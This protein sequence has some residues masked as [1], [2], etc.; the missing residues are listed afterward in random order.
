MSTM[1]SF[2]ETVLKDYPR[3]SPDNTF[4]F[5]CFKDIACF[6]QCCRDINIFLTPYDVMRLKNALKMTSSEF[7]EKYTL[8]PIDK[9]QQYPVLLLKMMDDE[10]KR[11]HFVGEQGC[12]VYE[13]RPWA[14]RMYPIGLASPKEGSGDEEFY[15]LM[16]EE[17]D[18]LGLKENKQ[19]SL[20]EWLD[21]Q[22][23]VRYN[24]AGDSFKQIILHDWFR[25][26]NKLTSLQMDMFHMVCYD[27]DRFRSFIFDS[28]FLQRFDIPDDQVVAMQEDDEALLEFGFQWLR[29]S[30]FGEKT[31]T[32]KDEAVA[33]VEAKKKGSNKQGK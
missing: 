26:D 3:M 27:L 22:G 29:F 30:L 4:S 24:K 13:D 6:N 11:C 8:M 20:R 18:C 17:H 15:F 28:T 19:W 25:E 9:N 7:L 23:I 21:D 14:C 5:S 33:A 1:E 12:T 10:A 2:K 16:H 31:L 32:V